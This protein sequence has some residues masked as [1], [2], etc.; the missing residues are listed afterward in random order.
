MFF[1]DSIR[2]SVAA[3]PP[4]SDE[5]AWI[6]YIQGR[7]YTTISA[8]TALR[9]AAVFRCVDLIAKTA[10]SLP[11]HLYRKTDNGREKAEDHHLYE[12]LHMLPN[13]YT[14][15]FEFWHMYIFNLLLTRGAYAKIVRDRNGFIRQLL[16]IPTA[17]VTSPQVNRVNGER[18]I[19]VNFGE[20]KTEVL[21]EGD[22]MY[23]P[24]LRFTNDIT[25]EDPIQIAADV[26]GLTIALNVYAKEYFDNGS[27][28]GGFIECDKPFSDKSYQRFKESWNEI[29]TGVK[30]A[31][32]IGFLEGGAKF[33]SITKNPNDSQALESRKHAVI[34][35][36]RIF[37][38][39]PHKAFELDRATF[40]N[41][42]QMNIE[43]V[44]E[45]I[46][47]MNVRIE[48]TIYKDL[49]T[50]PERKELYAKFQV[51]GLLRGDT[52]TR[53]KFYHDMRNDG[54]MN[55]DEIRELEDMNKQPNGQGEIYLINGN[56]ISV[57]NAAKNMPKGAVK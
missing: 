54:I 49:L 1:S 22:Y 33:N 55:A 56:M 52:A 19:I 50:T 47:P 11:L 46:T 36:C 48:Q 10:A 17:N 28:L 9:V 38:V 34:E 41:I 57:E 37:S 39:P 45:A 40:N 3:L 20:G 13:P 15:A 4:L 51:N 24:G 18:Y 32:K 43:F 26:L 35:I 2:N 6:A 29:Y 31:H 14:T 30:N 7:G 12:L 8:K 53:G 42:E 21:R 5:G 44:Q 27:N 23:T 16:N 25:P